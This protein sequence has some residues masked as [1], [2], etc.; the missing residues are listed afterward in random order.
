[1]HRSAS[2]IPALLF[3]L[4]CRIPL[5]AQYTPFSLS[6]GIAA[7]TEQRGIDVMLLSEIVSAKQEEV[8]YELIQRRMLRNLN[9]SGFALQNFVYTSFHALLT[10]KDQQAIEKELLAHTT[11]L[12]LQLGFGETLLRLSYSQGVNP[13]RSLSAVIEHHIRESYGLTPEQTT[14]VM[15]SLRNRLMSSQFSRLFHI[16]THIHEIVEHVVAG[17]R[18]RPGVQFSYLLMD[19]VFEAMRQSESLNQLGFIKMH[20]HLA[21]NYS[22]ISLIHGGGEHEMY[23]DFLAFVQDGMDMLVEY[24]GLFHE[25]I[26]DRGVSIRDLATS[27]NA[28]IPANFATTDSVRK[29]TLLLN[30]LYQGVRTSGE[31][32]QKI[33]SEMSDDLHLL[34]TEMWQFE[35]RN[36]GNQ[37]KVSVNDF[38][39]ISE[40]AE[41]TVTKL[42][43]NGVLGDHAWNTLAD[44]K[45]SIYARLLN[46]LTDRL[47]TDEQ[48]HQLADIPIEKYGHLIRIIT[49]LSRLDE[50]Q[51]YEQLFHTLS[52]IGLDLRRTELKYIKDVLYF[53][54]AFTVIDRSNRTVKMDVE[55]LLLKMLSTYGNHASRD[56]QPYFS[57]GLGQTFNI[58][59]SQEH[60]LTMKDGSPLKSMSFATEKL[61]FKYQVINNRKIQS[62]EP[63]QLNQFQSLFYNRNTS[64]SAQQP[65]VSDV[66]VYSY[67]SGLL[68]SVA[69]L[70]TAGDQFDHP[71]IGFGIGI[72][73]FNSLDFN[74]W[75]SSPLPGDEGL[76]TSLDRRAFWGFSFDVKLTEYLSALSKQKRKGDF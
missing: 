47:D 59:Q 66:Y 38:H 16:D 2:I 31:T 30:E 33:T 40:F 13:A 18:P 65:V 71:M 17:T 7:V 34:L 72:A 64:Y 70:T 11:I 20:P 60:A 62:S 74:I 24:H 52:Q 73:F 57:V 29:A 5:P 10:Y 48:F 15:Q 44:I 36:P 3:I 49:S 58:S 45:H 1:M 41:P 35:Q 27:A 22:G 4:F 9:G 8:K 28:S 6:G 76:L 55:P 42:V 37:L 26:N 50:V 69:D 75:R 56:F 21:K 25:F 68:Y 23:A 67:G 61:G 51:S 46:Q 53:V 19:T 63:W 12:A 39:F 54:E 32:A 14:E 43:S